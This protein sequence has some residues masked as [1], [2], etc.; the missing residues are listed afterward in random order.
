MNPAFWRTICSSRSVDIH[1]YPEHGER[2]L[3]ES[4]ASTDDTSR[5]EL[6]ELI[7]PHDPG[8]P[9]SPQTPRSD[10]K[11]PWLF[12][13]AQT[14]FSYYASKTYLDHL[15]HWSFESCGANQIESIELSLLP[16]PCGCHNL[17]DNA[18]PCSEL[19]R[20]VQRAD[21]MQERVIHVVTND[22]CNRESLSA[23][24]KPLGERIRSALRLR[25]Q[26]PKLSTV[27]I[28]P[29]LLLKA[30]SSAAEGKDHVASACSLADFKDHSQR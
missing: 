12:P 22:L 23:S 7:L 11:I 8:F 25:E 5:W 27:T 4:L 17:I 21:R 16:K 15:V 14:N 30:L 29:A 13:A 28:E 24:D 18:Q 26:F 10:T 3:A 9:T 1:E 19:F 2:T 6:A 20:D